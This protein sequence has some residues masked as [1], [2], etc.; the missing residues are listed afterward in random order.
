MTLLLKLQL[1][2]RD[3][4]KM[5]GSGVDEQLSAEEVALYDRQIRLWGLETQQRFFETR[6]T[7]HPN[8][9]LCLE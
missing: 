2:S 5:A 4:L 7:S 8:T 3:L 6:H 1:T 9:D